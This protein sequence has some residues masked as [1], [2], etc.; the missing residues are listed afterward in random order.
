MVVQKAPAL[1]LQLNPERQME[2]QQAE[3][4]ARLENQ[5]AEIN[6]KFDQMVGML[7]AAVQ[8]KNTKPKEEK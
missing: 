7:S 2:A 1:I 6:G 4:I 8:S 5:L 3:K